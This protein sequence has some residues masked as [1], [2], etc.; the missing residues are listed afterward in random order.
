MVH[1]CNEFS[2]RSAF[3]EAIA[4]AEAARKLL[5]L[6]RL[7]P[8]RHTRW[9]AAAHGVLRSRTARRPAAKARSEGA[10]YPVIPLRTGHVPQRGRSALDRIKVGCCPG[11]ARAA[12]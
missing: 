8:R 11:P 4:R 9:L 12:T 10:E 1:P 2:L 3:E 6:A 7:N 5:K